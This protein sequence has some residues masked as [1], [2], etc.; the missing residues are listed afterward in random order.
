MRVDLAGDSL[1]QVNVDLV[2]QAEAKALTKFLTHGNDRDGTWNPGI[3]WGERKETAKMLASGVQRLFSMAQALRRGDWRFANNFAP[4]AL[5]KEWNAIKD[6]PYGRWLSQRQSRAIMATPEALASGIVEFQNGWMPL[7]NDVRNAAEALANRNQ[8]A[9]WVITAI[10]KYHSETIDRRVLRDDTAFVARCKA[11]RDVRC[12]KA[13][14]VRLDATVGQ[15]HLHRVAQ[16]GMNNPASTF[17]QL[18]PGSYIVDHYVA[19][20]TWLASL[21]AVDGMKFYSGSM[22]KYYEMFAEITSADKATGAFY[23]SN[24][25]VEMQRTPYNGFPIPIAPLSMRPKELSMGQIFNQLSVL[26]L[27]MTGKPIDLRQ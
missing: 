14:K 3:A 13:V 5:R 27:W 22:T 7:Y 1:A 2:S 21:G 9:D 18:I 8:L 6:T 24:R 12:V 16:L 10:G 17:W 15:Q 25:I 26:Y 11:S 20:G 4:A 23:G 19:I